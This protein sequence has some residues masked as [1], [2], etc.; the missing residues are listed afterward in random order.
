MP[1][2]PRPVWPLSDVEV[3]GNVPSMD[4]DVELLEAW[5]AGDQKAAGALLSKYYALIRRN[6]ITKVP[7]QVVDDLV[8]KV[9]MALHEGRD[10]IRVGG[11]LRAYV[12]SVTKN[13]VYGYYRK[14]RHQREDSAEL[15]SSVRELG[16]GPS[17]ILLAQENDR[18]L[19]EAL[20]SIPLEDQFLL[21]LNYWERMTGP[22]LSQVFGVPESTIRSR[23]R[24][25]KERLR[26]Q[27]EELATDKRTLAETITDL[28][29][30]AER[31]REEL[32]AHLRRAG[33]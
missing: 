20:R 15:N 19:L 4:P 26:E 10:Q 33:K 17:S 11:K 23:L 24:R 32:Q 25:A 27:L 7:E 12:L 22:E 13:I 18:V 21:E 31:L 8:Q 6:V 16:A 5:R 29:A 1:K 14:Q 9:V 30:W 28:D 2:V 3:H